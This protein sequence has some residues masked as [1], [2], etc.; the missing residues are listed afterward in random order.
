MQYAQL[1]CYSS[2]RSPP[3]V[4]RMALHSTCARKDVQREQVST[5]GVQVHYI[6]TLLIWP[7]WEPFSCARPASNAATRALAAA[8]PWRST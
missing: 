1:G 3:A 8:F 4:K 7:P 5:T 6:Q 2:T